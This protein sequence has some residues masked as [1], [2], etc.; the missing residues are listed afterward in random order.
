MVDVIV[1]GG[2]HAAISVMSVVGRC[3]NLLFSFALGI[4]QGFELVASFNYGS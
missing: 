4:T 2:G 3:E 1:L